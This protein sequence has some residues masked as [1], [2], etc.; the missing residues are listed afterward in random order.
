MPTTTARLTPSPPHPKLHP[1]LTILRHARDQKTLT[2]G[3]HLRIYSQINPTLGLGSSAALTIAL[4]AALNRLHSPNLN[5]THIHQQALEHTRRI[6]TLA[7]GAD[8]AA[9]LHGTLHAYQI[10]PTRIDPLPINQ[11]FQL[12]LRYSG[13]KTPTAEVLAKIAHNMQQQPEHHQH[14]YQQMAHTTQTAINALKTHQPQ[15]L[16]RALNHY[17]TLLVALGVSD[18]TLERLIKEATPQSYASKIS[19]SGLGDCIVSLSAT[20]APPPT[21]HIPI[22]LAPQGL[23]HHTP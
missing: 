16:Y 8:L 21:H 10:N 13:Y 1:L 5:L 20:N 17:Q 11:P 18:P 3:L 23:I 9:S 6:Q 12:S 14:L 15:T 22:S 7:S 4:T 19:G 2:H